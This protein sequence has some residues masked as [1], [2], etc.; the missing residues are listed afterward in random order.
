MCT[1]HTP[2]D[3]ASTVHL[4]L[5]TFYAEH[6]DIAYEL[7]MQFGRETC[8]GRKFCGLG[9]LAVTEER[10]VR[11]W[12]EEDGEADEFVVSKRRLEAF[13]SWRISRRCNP[14]LLNER[15][16]EPPFRMAL[17]CL[18][19]VR[20]YELEHAYGNAFDIPKDIRRLTSIDDKTQ[21]GAL[22]RLYGTIYHQGS[23]F[24][25][26]VTS[27]DPL[28]QIIANT[29]ICNRGQIAELFFDI[30]ESAVAT[31]EQIKEKWALLS[32][33]SCASDDYSDREIHERK[34]VREE[35]ESHYSRLCDLALDVDHMVAEKFRRVTELVSPPSAR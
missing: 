10:V 20:W 14:A 27:I 18:D 13:S 23:I 28:L 34:C 29:S 8:F 12:I 9:H 5:Y 3:A 4:Q 22:G 17:E 15:T 33:L 19:H 1:V 21:S 31:P 35:I 6:R 11:K 7:A 26:T 24:P 2:F 25:A 30:A 32:R 16:F